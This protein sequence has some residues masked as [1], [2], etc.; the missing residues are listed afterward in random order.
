MKRNLFLTVILV[1]F[2]ILPAWADKTTEEIPDYSHIE[3]SKVPEQYKWK[4][5]DIYATDQDWEK[6]LVKIK[7]LISMIEEK[8][9]G[10]TDSPE[11]MLGFL[12]FMSEG[13]IISEKL[14]GYA[15]NQLN[16]EVSNQNLRDMT[17]RFRT[18]MIDMGSKVGFFRADI[19]ALGKDKFNEYV[20]AEP[21]LEPYRHMV[22]AILKMGDHSLSPDKEQI[23]SL[24]GLFSG[25]S[26]DAFGM[27]TTVEIPQPSVTLSDGKTYE[28]SY[29]TFQELRSSKNPEDR[30]KNM[31]TFWGNMKKFEKT[32]SL[33]YNSNVK[34]YFF[35]SK[36]RGY[37]GCLDMK[38]SQDDI[39]PKVYH[40]LI[41]SVRNNLKPLHD[42][43]T[44]KKELLGLETFKYADIYASSVKKIDKK[45]TWEEAKK[46]LNDALK[47]LGDNYLNIMNTALDN[48]W[49]DIYPNKDK[50]TGA[51]SSGVYS[52]H[53]FIKMNYTGT[54][55]N[56]ST[57][58]HELG[59]AIHTYLANKT[60]PYPTADYPI[61][62]AEI[63]ST[64]NENLLMDYMLKN[65]DDDLF[66]LFVLDEYMARVRSTIYRQTKF[67]EFEL[68]V[69]EY[70]EQGN[71]LTPDFMNKLYLDLTREYY[72]HDQG[73][74]IVDDYIQNEWST[75]P[76]FYRDFYVYQYSTGI[77]SSMAL[78]KGVLDNGAPAQERYLNFLK[79]G[80]SKYPLDTLKDAGIDL[81]TTE[82]MD[83]GLKRT[84]EIVEQMKELV[85]KLKK[86]GKL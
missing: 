48:R 19:L 71:T 17:S 9:K 47:P 77:I 1:L 36:V 25:V 62:L 80:G 6:D 81:T 23:L 73:I 5:N 40:N 35:F 76:H 24:T 43:I 39:D 18:A 50:A 22:D 4:I 52:V 32:L 7:K 66:K 72:G 2:L 53:P 41:K 15:T 33:L 49:V 21:G 78:T 37:D 16:M 45:F 30:E 65:S 85:A 28:L 38:L 20:K 51:Y 82:A 60:Q 34:N 55:S 54:Y 46:I 67:A 27:L 10:W 64:F 74:C 57:L 84:A 59:H 12:N 58:A 63:A 13:Q 31:L 61:F 83:Y 79:S 75:I 8:S 26:A 42:Y 68:K 44:L 11:K 70:V 14:G 56:V 86:E 69:H 3:R 29:Q